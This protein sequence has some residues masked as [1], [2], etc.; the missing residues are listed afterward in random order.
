MRAIHR[1]GLA[2]GQHADVVPVHLVV[3]ERRP[4]VDAR[5]LD[6][7]LEGPALRRGEELVARVRVVEGDLARRLGLLL[8]EGRLLP[9]AGKFRVVPVE[10]ADAVGRL[11]VAVPPQVLLDGRRGRACVACG[12]GGRASD[13]CARLRSRRRRRGGACER[14]GRRRRLVAIDATE[15]SQK[16]YAGRHTV[17]LGLHDVFRA[18][19]GARI[20]ISV[21]T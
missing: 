21:R 19:D 10:V 4:A 18:H 6:E 8:E 9:V 12:L 14:L 3:A 1:N 5:L 7:L 17:R 16:M 2:V 15:V 13:A 20:L 11:N